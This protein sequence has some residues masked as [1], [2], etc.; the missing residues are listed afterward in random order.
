MKR[1]WWVRGLK[2][3]AF[4]AIAVAAVGAVVM[5]LWN[6]LLPD[7]FGW[8]MI[9]YWQ[10]VGLLVL[11]KILLGGLR[12]GSG[13]GMHWRGRLMERWD[14]MTDEER[15]KFRDGMRRGCGG[16]GPMANPKV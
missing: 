15:A 6:A 1:I 16:S 9:G 10:A 11:S 3:M 8:H 7:L 12:G 5:G 2:F 4:A 13:H 14:Q